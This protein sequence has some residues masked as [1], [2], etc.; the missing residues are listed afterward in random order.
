M[1]SPVPFGTSSV[2]WEGVFSRKHT[3]SIS[4]SI[5]IVAA[6]AAQSF[7]GLAEIRDRLADI[8]A[9]EGPKVRAL[10]T[11]TTVPSLAARVSGRIDIRSRNLAS[12]IN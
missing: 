11:H 10:A 8:F 5:A 2:S 9:V 4:K 6:S 3:R 1:S 7:A 12:S